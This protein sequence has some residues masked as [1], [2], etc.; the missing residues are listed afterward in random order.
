MHPDAC[1][2]PMIAYIYF[3]SFTVICAQIFLNLFIAII[4]DSFLSQSDAFSLPVT[5]NDIDEFTDI[6]RE[7]DHDAKGYI[8]ASE[9]EDFIIALCETECNL[10][11]NRKLVR[12]D[13]SFRRRLIARMEIPAFNQFRNFLFYDVLVTMARLICEK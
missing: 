2:N 6:W 4:I 8:K 10:I 13:D 12:K 3:Y 7:F 5:Q 9:L 1:G 11:S